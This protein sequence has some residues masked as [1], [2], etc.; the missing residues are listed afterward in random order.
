MWGFEHGVNEHRVAIGN[1]RIFTV[2]DPRN[3]SP[4]LTGMDLV[5]LG[6]E[7]GRSARQAL[8]VM[9]ALLETHGQGGSGHAGIDWRYHNGF[10][11]AD[12]TEAWILETSD[13]H[14]A[15]RRV[16]DVGNVSN[17][18]D[19]GTDWEH[20]SADLTT[21]AV[22]EGWWPADGG[23]VHFA[24]AFR[25]ETGVPPNLAG[26]R[27]R[28]AATLL[29]DGRGRLTPASLRSILRDHYDDGPTHRPRAADDPHFFSLCMH[30]DPLDNTT[31]AMVA[32]LPAAAE[33]VAPA[34]VRRRQK[35]AHTAVRK[36]T[37]LFEAADGPRIL[38]GR[39]KPK[40]KKR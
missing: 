31:A 34:R 29:A 22:A 5:R 10:L 25:D 6:L 33:A 14:W 9:T 39:T 37:T 19:L 8:E 13:R 30:A 35:T 12:P 40:V 4:A 15:A 38:W 27:R 23:R 7:R 21:F 20:G 1:E 18:L 2:D 26:A 28:R 24:R 16:R 36:D 11:L 17:G 3:V 32:A